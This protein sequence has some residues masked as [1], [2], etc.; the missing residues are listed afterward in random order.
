MML[1]LSTLEQHISQTPVSDF[2]TE[3]V[4]E[5]EKITKNRKTFTVSH[6]ENYSCVAK[7]LGFHRDDLIMVSTA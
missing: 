7:D 5:K 2:Q 3:A 1:L 4:A 6:Q